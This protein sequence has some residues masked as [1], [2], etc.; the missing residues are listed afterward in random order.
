MTQRGPQPARACH[1]PSDFPTMSSS[2]VFTLQVPLG[3]IWGFRNLVV[4]PPLPE[5]RDLQTWVETQ[6]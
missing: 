2:P 5:S 6:F 1:Q 3:W 4:L